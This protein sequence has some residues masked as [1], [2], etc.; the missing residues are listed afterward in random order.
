MNILTRKVRKTQTN[1][2]LPACRFHWVGKGRNTGCRRRLQQ[3]H[4]SCVVYCVRVLE[5]ICVLKCRQKMRAERSRLCEHM[6]SPEAWSFRSVLH[7][8]TRVKTVRRHGASSTNTLSS[9]ACR[10]GPWACERPFWY[11]I[12]NH[13]LEGYIWL[14]G[15]W[16]LLP[17]AQQTISQ[18]LMRSD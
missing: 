9:R 14:V 17:R 5:K 10:T 2:G 13:K 12:G 15:T 18:S 8:G 1:N 3:K 6:I 16:R 11:G 7:T 4:P